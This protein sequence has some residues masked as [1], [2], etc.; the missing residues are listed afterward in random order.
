MTNAKMNYIIQSR[1]S[2]IALASILLIC[3]KVSA[4]AETTP[5]PQPCI[6]NCDC[7]SDKKMMICKNVVINEPIVDL[8]KSNI[9]SIQF[10]NTTLSPSMKTPIELNK[11]P[12]QTLESLVIKDSGIKFAS[13]TPKD[14]LVAPKLK[15]LSL[16]SSAI[17]NN[18]TYLPTLVRFPALQSL[19]LISLDSKVIPDNVYAN[20]SLLQKLLINNLTSLNQIKPNAFASLNNLANLTFINSLPDNF[21]LSDS[22]FANNTVLEYIN[23]SNNS[24]IEVPISL[25]QVKTVKTLNLN[26]NNFTSLRVS[27][28]RNKSML[29]MLKLKYCN[30]LTRIDDFT[31]GGMNNLQRVV[32]SNNPSLKDISKYAFYKSGNTNHSTMQLKQLDL[33]KNNLTTLDKDLISSV[34]P[35]EIVLAGNPWNCN[36]NLLWFKDFPSI[37]SSAVHCKE[38]K[39]FENYEFRNIMESI[40]CEEN[41][42]N[43]GRLFFEILTLILILLSIIAVLL[44]HKRHL[45]SRRLFVGDQFGT[46]YYTKASFEPAEQNSVIT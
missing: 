28:F 5:K 19:E 17:G 7:V 38:P 35:T 16:A 42:S 45:L 8:S 29:I 32:I 30:K 27:D 12:L 25:R 13:K 9:S 14:L 11:I 1:I 34:N 39:M 23:L 20:S 31:F 22:L 46:I 26:N 6:T 21:Y 36:C 40:V 44:Y 2:S 18:L 4:G 41:H 37:V 24:L 33:S 43:Y 3:L 15:F 10:I